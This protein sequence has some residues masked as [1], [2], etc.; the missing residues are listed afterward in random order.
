MKT[1]ISIFGTFLN[2]IPSPIYLA[3]A[4]V[5]FSAANAVTSRII[6]LGQAYTIDGRNPISF[7]N[8]LFVGNLCALGLMI[9]IFYPDWQIDK[10]KKL[11][12]KDWLL[13]TITAILSRAIA[14]GLMFSALDQTN[15]TNVV[16][17]GRLEPIFTLILSIFLLK[18]STNWL[19]ILAT[20]ISFIGVAVTVFWGVS[21]PIN[22][23][24]HFNFG[25]GEIFVAIA[26]FIS[27]ITTILS[28]QQLQ[29][30]PVSIFTVYRSLLGTFVFFWIAVILYG[31]DHFMDVFSPILWQW[32]L[33]YGAII[34]VLGQLFWLA[35]LKT[36][37]FIQ[38]NLASLVT[39]ILAIIFAYL[40]LQE[41]P[42]QA[43]YLGGTFL[44]VGAIIS[45]VDNLQASKRK[46]T[47]NPRQTMDTNVG[48][49]GV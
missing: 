41:T 40:I 3:L 20:L 28:K 29:S 39:P 44:L 16:L 47:L 37:S 23:V 49:R 7:C 6:E 45:F 43:Q 13:L 26:A 2:R 27:A 48:F 32:M 33:V 14:P 11:T 46:Q 21:D 1:L 38:I 25:L 22:M 31:F 35:G 9:L 8:V 12:R 36:A 30:I 15:V 34:V 19:S 24:I 18:A 10:L 5:I 17:I 42:T 4:V